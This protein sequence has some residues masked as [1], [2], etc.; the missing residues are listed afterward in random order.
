[1]LNRS[2]WG[3][4]TGAY[5]GNVDLFGAVARWYPRA[6]RQGPADQV[7]PHCLRGRQL[8]RGGAV[9]GAR[10]VAQG[11]A[12]ACL[13]QPVARGQEWR[14]TTARPG[15][16]KALEATRQPASSSATSANIFNS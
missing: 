12:F 4:Q 5:L 16:P 14:A 11:F 2:Q 8:G 10:R 15:G 9:S 13:R 7:F 3:A 1:M 6:L